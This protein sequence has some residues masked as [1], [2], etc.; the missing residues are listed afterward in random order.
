MYIMYVIV[1]QVIKIFLIVWSQNVLLE[2]ISKVLQKHV[3]RVLD[4]AQLSTFLLK[5]PLIVL[6]AEKGR[7]GLPV[8]LCHNKLLISDTTKALITITIVW[9]S[10]YLTYHVHVYAFFFFTS[11]ITVAASLHR[12][13][14]S[15]SGSSR[16][17]QSCYDKG[18]SDPDLPF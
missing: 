11:V 5:R 9:T 6:A 4:D 2:C 14:S 18:L 17:A 15:G 7:A 13:T 1:Y 12:Y 3:Y 10:N 8:L 16:R